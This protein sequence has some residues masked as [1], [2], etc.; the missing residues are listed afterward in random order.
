MAASMQDNHVSNAGFVILNVDDSEGARYAKTRI[1]RRAGFEVLEAGNGADALLRARQD[2]PDLVLLDVKLPD[3]NGF[4]VCRRIKEDPATESILVLQTSASFVEIAD[5]VR[6]LDGGADNYLVEPIEPEELIANVNALLRLRRVEGQL[7]ES[8]ERFRQIAENIG[9]VFW[10]FSPHDRDLLYISPAYETLWGRSAARLRER[11]DEWLDGVHPEDRARVQ[12]AFAKL[13]E[14]QYYDEEYRLIR[15]DGSMRWV[16]DR[17]FPVRNKADVFYRVARIS[18]DITVRKTAENALHETD[19]RKDEFLATLAHELRNPLGPIRNAVELLRRLGP[20]QTELHEK[21]R[22]MIGRQTDHL[23]RLV[24]DLLDI[25]RITQGKVALKLEPVK[26][27]TFI[28]AALET[29]KP[30]I[31]SRHHHL[32]VHLPARDILVMGD[33]VRLCQIVGNLLHNAGKYTPQGGRVELVADQVGDQLVITVSDNGIGIPPSGITR[34]FDLFAQAEHSPDRA[35][36]GLGIGLSLVKSLVELHGGKVRAVSAGLGAGSTFEI[37]LPVVK[38]VESQDAIAEPV[39]E[40]VPGKQGRRI[41]VVDDNP[42]SVEML[43]MLLEVGGHQIRTAS[44]GI[45][46]IETARQYS[47][48]IVFLDIGLPGMSGYDVARELRRLPSMH[49]AT[50]IAL[51]GYGQERDRQHALDAGFDHH[52]VKPVD[53]DRLARLIAHDPA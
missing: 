12:E 22:Q 29:V 24:D 50:L 39:F 21:A 47:P 35:Q 6:A 43:T 3:M 52:V 42:D 41:L 49:S 25:S 16:R 37:Q 26:V 20:E 11:F 53:F 33:A 34:V 7:R 31:D 51:T 38:D 9:D 13:R 19:R 45:G 27:T 32:N 15:P 48:E 2:M 36:D 23:V 28:S 17:G 44:N 5:K 30:F 1:L 14:E 10:M 40:R 46:A 4:E 18:H 8:E